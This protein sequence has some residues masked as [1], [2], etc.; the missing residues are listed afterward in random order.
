MSFE[1]AICARP[2]TLA[3][4]T[5][6]A[7]SE[8]REF[9]AVLPN[10]TGEEPSD[11]HGAPRTVGASPPV[12]R[13]LGSRPGYPL[14][15]AVI[16]S[17][18]LAADACGKRA[19]RQG[20]NWRCPGSSDPFGTSGEVPG[21]RFGSHA[22]ARG[23]VSSSRFGDEAHLTDRPYL[24]G[25]SALRRRP[26]QRRAVA[27][28][29]LS[30]NPTEPRQP[31]SQ[32]RRGQRLAAEPSAPAWTQRE[33]RW[34]RDRSVGLRAGRTPSASSG[35]LGPNARQITGAITRAAFDPFYGMVD[36]A[37]TA[38]LTETTELMANCVPHGE[39]WCDH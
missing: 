21:S 28:G 24:V 33:L 2:D 5:T 1:F 30:A 19:A 15:S 20:E 12:K 13:S 11:P 22:L 38:W 14:K 31:P 16:V 8:G 17:R 29:R 10:P 32:S 7:A 18:D 39:P 36:E 37:R 6:I 9:R 4:Q 25:R 3:E 27:S 35:G 34:L 26:P 23:L